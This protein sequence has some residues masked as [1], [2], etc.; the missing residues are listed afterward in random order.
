M[1]VSS[2][3]RDIRAGADIDLVP[4]IDASLGLGRLSLTEHTRRR[5]KASAGPVRVTRARRLSLG[6]AEF[7]ELHTPQGVYTVPADY[8]VL[9]ACR[10]APPDAAGELL[11]EI[12]AASSGL[13]FE[14]RRAAVPAGSRPELEAALALLERQGRVTVS[15]GPSGRLVFARR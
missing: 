12:A 9:R 11:G 13:D 6:G 1:P 8:P 15:A 7:A 2:P 4:L 3:A 10:A 5:A 14:A